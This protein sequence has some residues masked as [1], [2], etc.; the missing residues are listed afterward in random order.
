MQE[1]NGDI[2]KVLAAYNAGEGTV[3]K[4]IAR[5][6]REGGNWQDYLPDETKGYLRKTLPIASRGQ[7][8]AVTIYNNTGGNAVVVA[9]A[10]A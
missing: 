6:R 10:M 3:E 5:A 9:S 8:V 4:D 2:A 1:F 7:A